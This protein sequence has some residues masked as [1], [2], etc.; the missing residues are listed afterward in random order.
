[1][2]IPGTLMAVDEERRSERGPFQIQS[3]WDLGTRQSR[4]YKGLFPRLIQ[5]RWLRAR[6]VRF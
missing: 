4:F 3:S 1:M 2:E 5:Y 6:R